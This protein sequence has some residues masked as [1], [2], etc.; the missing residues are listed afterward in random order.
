[1]LNERGK[2]YANVELPFAVGEGG[3]TVTDIAGRT[4]HPDGS[5][6]PF[7]GKP[8]EKLI[9][10][11][12]GF[13][14]K[15]KVFTL[16]AVDVG[17][18][19]EYRYNTRLDDN[20]Y[21]SPDWMIQSELY[22]RKAHYMW[23]PTRALIE[24]SDGKDASTNVAWTPILPAGAQV[25]QKQLLGNSYNSSDAPNTELDLDVHDI[26]ALPKEDYMP[27]IA[28]VSYRVL[29]Y[30]TDVRTPKEF[31]DR[32]GKRW[33]KARD[34]FVGPG[35]G[36]KNYVGS[37]VSPS[38]T[39]DQKA[40]KLYAAVMQLENTDFT[41]ER[42]SGEEK[43][44]GLKQ[45]N[46]TEDVLARKRGS[47]DQLA[48]L[49]VAMCRAAGLKAYVMAVSD[50][51][52]HIFLPIYL[53]LYQLDDLIAIVNIDGKDVYF[54]PGQ[55]Y[56]EP[57]QL[58]WNHSL[59]GGL[60]Q[61]EGGGGA[62]GG[63]PGS[64]Y[65]NAL[66]KRLADLTLDDHGAA[67]GTV[68]LSLTGDPALR[69]RQQALRGDETSLKDDLRTH[70]EEMLPGGLE[71][72]VTSVD[73]LTDYDKP[74]VVHYDLKGPIGSSTGKR[75]L[76]PA[77]LFESNEKPRFPAEKR[78]IG[79]DMHYPS[80]VHDV[81]RFKYP[82][83]IS[84]ES[85]PATEKE[86]LSNVAAFDDTTAKS[87]PNSVTIYRNLINGRTLFMADTY[88]ELRSFYNKVETKDQE[89]LILTHS[90]V[91]SGAAKPAGN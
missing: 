68:S 47:G 89:P 2:E 87:S 52:Q 59:V 51:S 3:M 23:R 46:S 72:H 71:I 79:I 10:K 42:T 45:I 57:E 43:A 82:D 39:Q 41:R 74:L 64:V 75:L 58:A 38:D 12:G 53:S 49:F 86:T 81:V 27:P 9:V 4:I 37:L 61:V 20:Y 88:K 28:S 76:V 91:A 36:V 83:D 50:R 30:Y 69:W 85:A 73:N 5:I 84:V 24:T 25:V 55:R 78:E 63:T 17:S 62:V 32:E 19:I 80:Y 14:S 8:Y 77:N 29:F 67:S 60:R 34:K 18:I 48:E 16:P 1:V 40:R 11:G 44:A 26:P 22:T 33:S 13:Q 31:W 70:L 35:S 6:V 21:R 90:A 66:V 54:D 7:T 15:A 65:T 56:C